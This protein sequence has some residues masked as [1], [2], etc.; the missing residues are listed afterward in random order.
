MNIFRVDHRYILDGDSSPKVHE[1]FYFYDKPI[2]SNKQN[3]LIAFKNIYGI[4]F[5]IF[6]LK[7]IH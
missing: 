4:F 2:C 3:K 5:E 7:D 6:F 1:P